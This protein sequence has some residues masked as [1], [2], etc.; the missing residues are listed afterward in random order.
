[1]DLLITESCNAKCSYC[2]NSKYRNEKATMDTA[3]A[4]NLLD[5][6]AQNKCEIVRLM[7]GEPTLHPDFP[8]IAE[9]CQQLFPKVV[10]LTNAISSSIEKFHPRD[11]DG[12]IYNFNTMHNNFNINKMLYNYPGFR[13]ISIVISRTTD[14]ID[15]E[16]RLKTIFKHDELSK[17]TQ[18]NIS[19]D[20]CD[21]IF[22]KTNAI[23]DK[24]NRLYLLCKEKKW[25]CN[26]RFD[27]ELV[28]LYPECMDD[29]QPLPG[30]AKKKICS[31]NM[32][33]LIDANFNFVFCNAFPVKIGSFDKDTN[34]Y[35]LC[36]IAKKYTFERINL[37]KRR[38]SKCNEHSKTCDG[39]CFALTD[40]DG[41]DILKSKL[42][43]KY[44][45]KKEIQGV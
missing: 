37:T 40:I 26:F 21:N 24:I 11:S 30:G 41:Y 34:W 33:G 20:L 36:E 9:R 17:R 43:N 39:T 7:G 13:Y 32:P 14:I 2:L 19:I 22:D 25:H 31:R 1:M 42:E 29:I 6:L 44:A 12:I 35:Q 4:L 45:N 5:F 16:N 27:G 23:K 15:L 18:L 38:C 3:K 10:V 8:I 28:I